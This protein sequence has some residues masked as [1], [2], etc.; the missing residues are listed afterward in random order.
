MRKNNSKLPYAIIVRASSGDVEAI[1]TVI[2]HY[3]GYIAALA[4]RT[5]YDD[6]G[7]PH[8]YVDDELRR[9]LETKLIT[10]LLDF[11]AA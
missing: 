1:Q 10:K 2:Q 7:S 3:G 5:L 6:Q 11:R 4:T 8:L 9:I